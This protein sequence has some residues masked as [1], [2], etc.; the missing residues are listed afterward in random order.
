LKCDWRKARNTQQLV[1]K[2]TNKPI[3]EK[4]TNAKEMA[5]I[6]MQENID[7]PLPRNL[8]EICSVDV[9]QLY[10]DVGLHNAYGDYDQFKTIFKPELTNHTAGAD[11]KVKQKQFYAADVD[12]EP[13]YLGSNIMGRIRPGDNVVDVK[14]NSE[15]YRQF[16]D[17]TD[18]SL[19]EI[20]GTGHGEVYIAY[21][22][23]KLDVKGSLRDWG[24]TAIQTA[25][26]KNKRVPVA[27]CFNREFRT[28]KL[29]H[30]K[31]DSKNPLEY[32]R[33][34][35]KMNGGIL[36]WGKPS[37]YNKTHFKVTISPEVEEESDEELAS[38][39][40]GNN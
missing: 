13:E 17:A 29:F 21:P 35:H 34:R 5:T 12:K 24:K 6:N 30:R 26:R 15:G 3:I 14:L 20:A 8:M 28:N 31:N 19:Q 33:F 18:R 40:E 22:H 9:E 25:I 37:L 38:E 36:G 1:Y 2:Q 10:T 27:V 16:Y 23:S 39:E 7:N 11:V 4:Q 32:P